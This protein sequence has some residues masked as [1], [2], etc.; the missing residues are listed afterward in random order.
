MTFVEW[1]SVVV[2]G[3]GKYGRQLAICVNAYSIRIVFV[4]GGNAQVQV[5][6]NVHGFRH[7]RTRLRHSRHGCSA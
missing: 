1:K 6:V 5:H 3:Y 2:S 4:F 7:F